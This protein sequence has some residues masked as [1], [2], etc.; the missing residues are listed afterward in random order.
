MEAIT[1]LDHYR[2]SVVQS[3]AST[4]LLAYLLRH[5][6]QTEGALAD[7]LRMELA[8]IRRELTQLYRASLVEH[9]TDDLWKTSALA[10]GILFR[11]EIHEA[12]TEDLAKSLDVGR[13][14]LV[15]LNACASG[16]ED[17][18]QSRLRLWLLRCVHGINEVFRSEARHEQNDQ[19][20]LLFYAVLYGTDPE[21]QQI[22]PEGLSEF[23]K[24]RLQLRA[25][26]QGTPWASQSDSE[27]SEAAKEF[28]LGAKTYFDSNSLLIHFQG[29]GSYWDNE[30]AE[31]FTFVR[32]LSACIAGAADRGFV[33]CS[34]HWEDTNYSL[35][36]RRLL[37]QPTFAKCTHDLFEK[38][39]GV[40]TVNYDLLLETL[41]TRLRKSVEKELP[42]DRPSLWRANEGQSGTDRGLDVMRIMSE[43]RLL[44]D[45]L[46][47]ESLENV[48]TSALES[49][50]DRAVRI[51]ER[52][53]EYLKNRGSGL[54]KACS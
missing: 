48:A 10:D 28:K 16:L 35:L 2:L 8:E 43:L 53:R 44:E 5:G 27:V 33:S 17:E 31:R 36:W 41:A 29:H 9:S 11:L 23:L 7:G 14:A 3:E 37:D 42:V 38:W 26:R 22:S 30:V 19:G 51:N 21:A 13:P 6:P 50:A 34:R 25:R 1:I 12:A 40:T 52:L 32:A 24:A 45:S 4:R 18:E 49:L 46:D 15:T 54:T 39:T 47:N 20:H